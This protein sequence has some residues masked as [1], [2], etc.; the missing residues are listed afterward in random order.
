MC[1]GFFNNNND[2]K[3]KKK[4]KSVYISL[5]FHC[6]L[7][8]IVGHGYSRPYNACHIF[9]NLS[10]QNATAWMVGDTVTCTYTC[11]CRKMVAL[12]KSYP[13]LGEL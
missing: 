13:V 3:E 1:L 9:Y 8:T 5:D 10:G 4:C 2:N 6:S 11:K 7:S 12:S